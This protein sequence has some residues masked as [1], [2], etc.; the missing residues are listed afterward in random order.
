[1]GVLLDGDALFEEALLTGESTPVRK[2]A[3]DTVFAGTA[4]REHA[5]RVRITR[6][7]GDTRLA[8]LIRL[9]ERAQAHRPALA[10]GTQ[11][12]ASWFVAGLLLVAMLADAG[13]RLPH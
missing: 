3:G 2:R 13:W 12:I 1:D 4:C 8:E 5:A 6:V 7:G 10:Q 11:R 9:V